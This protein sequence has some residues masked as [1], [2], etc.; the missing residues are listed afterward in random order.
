MLGS[1]QYPQFWGW[2]KVANRV[3][4]SPKHADVF[5]EARYNLA[6]CRMEFAMTLKG[7]ERKEQLDRAKDDILII[8]RLYPDMGGEIWR[9]KYNELFKRI[10]KVLG[11]SPTGLPAPEKSM[12]AAPTSPAKAS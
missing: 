8:G 4:R 1:K 12:A 7:D 11:E 5:H 9:A 6:V 10:Q 3:A 2:G